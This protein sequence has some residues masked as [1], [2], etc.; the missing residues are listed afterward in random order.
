[1][2]CRWLTERLHFGYS[3]KGYCRRTIETLIESWED[4]GEVSGYRMS[5]ETE[6]DELCDRY[7]G[8]TAISSGAQ[9]MYSFGT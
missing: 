6:I 7:P 4:T 2:R 1:M 9:Q 5:I 8:T 3:R